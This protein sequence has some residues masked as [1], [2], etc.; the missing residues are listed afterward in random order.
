MKRRAK[1]EKGNEK[2]IELDVYRLIWL[3]A[4]LIA[5]ALTVFGVIK[6]VQSFMKVS[7]FEITGQYSYEQEDIIDS[8]GIRL[9]D[10]L[11]SIDKKEVAENILTRCPYVSKVRVDTKF[12][13]TVVIELESYSTAWYME[14]EGDFYALTVD[15]LVLEETSYEQQFIDGKITKLTLPNVKSAIVGQTLVYGNDDAEKEFADEFMTMINK[16]TFK[17]RLSLV[18][19]DNR[20]DINMQIDG[21]IDVY[22]GKRTNAEEKLKAVEKALDDDRLDSCISAKIDVSDP[23]KVVISPVYDYGNTG[24]DA[25]NGQEALG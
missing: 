11:Y 17:S 4:V 9:G 25:Q 15:L 24:D 5:T 2:V 18:D 3:V 20:F 12:P 22:I 6:L 8:S 19:I 10:K 7:R 23:K 1:R 21:V 16:M 14:I 13:N